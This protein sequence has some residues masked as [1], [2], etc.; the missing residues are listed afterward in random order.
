MVDNKHLDRPRDADFETS[1][2][3]EQTIISQT[4]ETLSAVMT[5]TSETLSKGV[6]KVK[7]ELQ[8]LEDKK[9]TAL[10]DLLEELRVGENELAKE[11]AVIEQEIQTN[12]QRT[13]DRGQK[14][15]KAKAASEAKKQQ[16]Q[17]EA[18]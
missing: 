18:D 5:R 13:L 2:V 4:V 1:A 7:A 16:R 10:E 6:G 12:K 17:H 3:F 8:A 15:E 11:K 9:R 14:L